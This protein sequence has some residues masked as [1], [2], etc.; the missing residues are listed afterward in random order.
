MQPIGPGMAVFVAALLAGCA[1][2]LGEAVESGQGSDATIVIRGRYT[3]SSNTLHALD[4][5]M[6][7]E[8]NKRCPSGWT[9][10][11]D[12]NNPHSL[13]GG[14]IWRVR[15]NPGGASASALAAAPPAPA[16]APTAGTA[17][18][19]SAEITAAAPS[20]AAPGSAAITGIA[21]SAQ[22]TATGAAAFSAAGPARAISREDLVRML[23]AA[24]KRASPYLTDSAAEV[25]VAE[26]LRTLAA[27]RVG[28]LGPDGQPLPL[29]PAR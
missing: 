11:S 21:P 26:Q 20:A 1:S 14:R 19:A 4:Q 18:Q 12:E 24:V 28:V 5:A 27:A 22:A 3:E 23:A 9:K 6:A 2:L 16:L 10:V 17:T 25:I 13:T 29:L 7:V 8:A 15:C